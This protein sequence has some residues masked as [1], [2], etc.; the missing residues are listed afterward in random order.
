[1]STSYPVFSEVIDADDDLEF[2]WLCQAATKLW[3]RWNDAN[4]DVKSWPRQAE[5]LLSVP[6]DEIYS[7]MPRWKPLKN[8]KGIVVSATDGAAL[9]AIPPL[10]QLYLQR[11]HSDWYWF[12]EWAEI[13]E[14]PEPAGFRGGAVF[15]TEDRVAWHLTSQWVD[16]MV[17]RLN[18]QHP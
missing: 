18:L 1:M 11:F 6:F 17:E 8:R 12:M 3:G 4:S 5:D 7:M 2:R 14:T 16:G 10:V 13:S 15:V 9:H